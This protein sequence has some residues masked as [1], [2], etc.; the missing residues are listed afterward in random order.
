MA[1]A[2]EVA[3][4]CGARLNYRLGYNRWEKGGGDSTPDTDFT[5]LEIVMDTRAYVK[6]TRREISKKLHALKCRS[7]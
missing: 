1:I 6:R 3:R 5:I 4:V 7:Q 2:L